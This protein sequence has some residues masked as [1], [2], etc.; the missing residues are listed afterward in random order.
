MINWVPVAW[1]LIHPEMMVR[2]FMKYGIS[3]SVDNLEDSPIWL[4]IPVTTNTDNEEDDNNDD[5]PF[6]DIDEINSFTDDD[7]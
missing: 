3:N 4:E 6:Q 7:N 1:K 5:H 2:S